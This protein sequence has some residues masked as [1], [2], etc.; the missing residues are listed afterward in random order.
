M[1]LNR[2]GLPQHDHLDS[3]QFEILTLENASTLPCMLSDA[4]YICIKDTSLIN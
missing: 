3:A 2:K 1:L 4:T